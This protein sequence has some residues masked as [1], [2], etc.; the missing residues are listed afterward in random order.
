MKKITLMAVMLLA[1][2]TVFSQSKSD[3][4]KNDGGTTIINLWPEKPRVPTKPKG[5]QPPKQEITKEKEP[6]VIDLVLNQE[7][8]NT[9]KNRDWWL[10]VL[11]LVLAGFIPAVIVALSRRRYCSQGCGCQHCGSLR[12]YG[13]ITHSGET[14]MAGNMNHSGTVIHEHHQVP[15]ADQQ[16]K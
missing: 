15:P 5:N 2:A 13:G 4:I 10:I 14:T 11:S 12:H 9:A 1:T 6:L 16:A 8:K 3:T 7:E